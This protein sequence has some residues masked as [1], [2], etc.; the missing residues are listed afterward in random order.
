MVNYTMIS[1]RYI[2]YLMDEPRDMKIGEWYQMKIS[3]TNTTL[4]KTAIYNTVDL[5]KEGIS[6]R[7]VLHLQIY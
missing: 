5:F 6:D 3:Y 2:Y 1:S 7:V 4:N